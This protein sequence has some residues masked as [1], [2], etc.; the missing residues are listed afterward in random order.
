MCVALTALDATVHVD[1]PRGKR[2]IPFEAFHLL[3]GTTPHLETTLGADELITAV[4]L[5]A[6]PAGRWTYRKIRDRASYAFA[7]VSVAAALDVDG[8][9]VRNVRLALGGVAT[10]PW[11]A[12]KA[13]AALNGAEANRDAF[14][15]AAEAEMAD[16]RGYGDN[17]F[18][19]ELARRAITDV[20]LEL[21]DGEARL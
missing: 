12:H 16:A 4:E 1:G 2:S 10:K 8:G 15:R 21:A 3:P 11:R 7:L 17:D 18:K 5:P 19:I 14:R 13:E 6:P 20:L 9:R